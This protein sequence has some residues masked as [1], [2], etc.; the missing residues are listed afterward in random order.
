MITCFRKSKIIP[1][2]LTFSLGISTFSAE[3]EIGVEEFVDRADQALYLAKQTGRDR[4]CV[5][6]P[7]LVRD[8]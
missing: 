3:D 1:K 4:V 5:W 2:P 8:H 7:D 6:Q